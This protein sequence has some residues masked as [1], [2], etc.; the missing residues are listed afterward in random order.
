VEEVLIVFVGDLV[1]LR[2]DGM[3]AVTLGKEGVLGL[4]RPGASIDRVRN[5]S[6]YQY[7]SEDGY[8]EGTEG[9]PRL[10][11]FGAIRVGR[12]VGAI[13]KRMPKG[14]NP[15][16]RS[17]LHVEMINAISHKVLVKFFAET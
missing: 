12:V 3:L 6:V 8:R 9:A 13:L 10:G 1:D 17:Y 5:V 14:T 7:I 2:S 11:L 15:S 16:A 4:I